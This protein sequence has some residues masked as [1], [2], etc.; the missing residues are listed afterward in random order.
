MRTATFAS[1][2]RCQA[3]RSSLSALQ[4]E[5]APWSAMA[6]GVSPFFS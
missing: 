2:V 6:R 1:E 3:F 4:R 5:H